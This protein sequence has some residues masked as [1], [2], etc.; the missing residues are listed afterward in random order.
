M[1]QRIRIKAYCILKIEGAI[2]SSFF[3]PLQ[4]II[5]VDLYAWCSLK[6]IVQYQGFQHVNWCESNALYMLPSSPNLLYSSKLNIKARIHQMLYILGCK[7]HI[8]LDLGWNCRCTRIGLIIK[9]SKMEYIIHLFSLIHGFYEIWKK[10]S[11]SFF[12]FYVKQFQTT[13][14]WGIYSKWPYLLYIKYYSICCLYK[15]T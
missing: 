6:R 12:F 3:L 9:S 4:S 10:S 5:W 8:K 14:C 15:S 2:I 1:K 11:G 7:C 13:K